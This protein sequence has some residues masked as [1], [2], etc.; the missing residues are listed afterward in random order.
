MSGCSQCLEHASLANEVNGSFDC[1]Q[2]GM[3]QTDRWGIGGIQDGLLVQVASETCQGLEKDRYR[4]AWAFASPFCAGG[5][6]EV[7]HGATDVVFIGG[8][9]TREILVGVPR[10]IVHQVMFYFGTD[11]YTSSEV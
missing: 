4:A 8:A 1:V 10:K 2:G 7:G 9:G 11:V 3:N 5:A 6:M